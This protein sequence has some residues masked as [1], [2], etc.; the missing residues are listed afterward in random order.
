MSKHCRHSRTGVGPQRRV[1]ELC[2][3]SVV[4]RIQ[5]RTLKPRQWWTA[6]CDIIHAKQQLS[7]DLA[8]ST[9][10]RRVVFAKA[11]ER[12]R[13]NPCD[14]PR[15]ACGRRGDPWSNATSRYIREFKDVV[16][17]DV[18]F[19]NNSVV[20]CYALFVIVTSIQIYYYQTPHPQTPHP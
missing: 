8:R 12:T 1:L 10:S 13:T 9:A 4:K 20:P 5:Y 6:T 3:E 19:D 16:F 14:T 17:E 2:G 11:P 15:T 7:R 18:V